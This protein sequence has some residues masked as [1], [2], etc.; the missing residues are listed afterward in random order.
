MEETIVNDMLKEKV[1]ALGADTIM[2]A[3]SQLDKD[4]FREKVDKLQEAIEA[5]E[6]ESE[7]NKDVDKAMVGSSTPVIRG[8]L[9]KTRPVVRDTKKIQRNDPCPC[10]SGKKYKNCCMNSGKYETTHFE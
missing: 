8:W 7:S 6:N 5:Q 3:M 2:G 10:G 4:N 9:P 1:E